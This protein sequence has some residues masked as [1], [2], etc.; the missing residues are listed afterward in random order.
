MQ[1]LLDLRDLELRRDMRLNRAQSLRDV[2]LLE[3]RLFMR[4]ID[5]Q[6]WRQKISQLVRAFDAPN[7]RPGSFWRVRR[8]LE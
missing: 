2:Q 8:Q 5:I 7:D 1:L 4:K 3:Q 6:I